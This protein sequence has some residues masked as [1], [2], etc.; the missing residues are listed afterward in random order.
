MITKLEK[1]A[2]IAT[3]CAAIAICLVAGDRFWRRKPPKVLPEAAVKDLG[4][5]PFDLTHVQTKGTVGAHVIIVGFSDFECPFCA[6]HA[7]TVGVELD[8]EFVRPG[9]ARHAFVNFPL[10][11]HKNARFLAS[12]AICAAQQGQFWKLYD[13]LFEQQS[14][15][16]TDPRLRDFVLSATSDIGLDRHKVERCLD[17]EGPLSAQI[18]GDIQTAQRLH[19]FST[20]S[21]AIGT[22]DNQ[23]KVALTKMIVGARPLEDFKKVLNDMLLK[24]GKS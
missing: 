4:S 20:P 15:T 21:F 8:S 19:I 12:A 7:T 14:K 11:A 18:E 13:H 16:H 2:N 9:K 5:T 6:K 22:I 1:A 17:N 24:V 10:A 23:G 3:V